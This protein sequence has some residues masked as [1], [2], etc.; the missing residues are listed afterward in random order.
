MLYTHAMTLEPNDCVHVLN[1]SIANLRLRKYDACELLLVIRCLQLILI[2][3]YSWEEAKVD[4]TTALRL[5]GTNAVH[6][7][8]AL[9][10][11]SKANMELGNTDDAHKGQSLPHPCNTPCTE[12]SLLNL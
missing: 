1:R 9:F 7:Q 11:R 6:K 8:K 12:P 4:A 3:L 10:R 2:M 5:C